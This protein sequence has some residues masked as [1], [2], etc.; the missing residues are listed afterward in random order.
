MLIIL[1]SSVP[2]EQKCQTGEYYTAGSCQPCPLGQYNSKEGQT[3]CTQC[4]D[5]KET[6]QTGRSSVKDC[7]RKQ[8]IISSFVMGFPIR[9][10]FY[11]FN[12]LP[13]PKGPFVA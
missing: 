10:L 11:Q 13:L 8:D 3:S 7:Y 5:S 6:L 4:P 1:N 9:F 12:F 2:A